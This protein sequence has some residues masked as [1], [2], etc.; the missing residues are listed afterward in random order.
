MQKDR[1]K[2]TI[3]IR[4][5]NLLFFLVFLLFTVI[6]F[7]LSFVQ[8]VEGKNYRAL[9]N[10]YR[11]KSI[12]ITAPRGLIK[13][14][15]HQVLVNNK[16]IWTVTFQINEQQKQ[17]YDQIAET[18]ANL[19]TKPGENKQE[20]KKE[21]LAS[22]DVGPFYKDSKYIPRTILEDVDVKTRAYIEEHKEELPGV[23]VIP[24][25]MRNYLYK[26]FMAQTIG[27]TRKIPAG[28][29]EY[30][31]ALGYKSSDRIG[32]RGLEK[33]YENVL[34]GKDGY[35]LVEVNSSYE[36]VRQKEYVPPIPGNNIILTI[37]KN[38]QD[39]V[40]KAL[41]NQIK[42]LKPK[43][44]DA[45]IG[46]AV[47]MNPKTGAV[48]ALA[49]YPRYD[50]NI[51]NDRVTPDMWK[52]IMKYEPNHAIQSANSVG[53]TYKPLTVLM[54][55]QENVITTSTV[56][57]DTGRLQYDRRAD[58]SAIVMKNFEGHV[59]GPLNLQKALQKSSNIFMAEIALR[60][61]QKYGIGKTLDTQRYYDHMFGL[62][63][64]TGIDLPEETTGITSTA[65]NYVQHSIGQ[66]DT[67]TVMQLAQYVSTIANDGYRMKPY[68]VQAIEEGTQSGTGGRIIYHRE[69][70]VLN[71]V[72][73][74]EKYIQAVKQGMYLVTQPGGTAYSALKGLPIK[75]GA[76]TGT[77]QAADRSKEDNAV[78]I[79]FAPFDDP[80]IAFAIM[81]PHGGTGGGSAGPVARAIIEAYLQLGINNDVQDVT[82]DETPSPSTR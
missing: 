81:I 8:L 2:K 68:L 80:E 14:R 53:S 82:A 46:M 3:A 11:E 23:E 22:M 79:G 15:N 16:T 69:P 64:K 77:A 1:V 26:D 21:I 28:E 40:E 9:A 67:F 52:A 38:F 55:L 48:L 58:G 25:Q 54:G 31:Q 75:V 73:I 33:Q 45:E 61:K 57:Q 36:T 39:A 4:R 17:D 41:E 18:L 30:Y 32:I 70:E 7:R 49:N 72:P 50:L 76:K 60:M 42:A 19:V 65:P 5:M 47:V 24:D 44:K 43:H 56:I 27:Y 63:V 10:T 35:T 74:P 59:Y 13:D 71:K 51:W 66:H 6:I 78:F 29:L 12:P 20:I 34:H 37:D 62:G